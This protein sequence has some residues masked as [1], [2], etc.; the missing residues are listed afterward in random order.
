MPP[1]QFMKDL[2]YTHADKNPK[3]KTYGMMQY[4]VLFQTIM[5]IVFIVLAKLKTRM[6]Y[7]QNPSLNSKTPPFPSQVPFECP[8]N[9]N[10]MRPNTIIAG[11]ELH[12]A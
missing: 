11:I 12:P 9:I 3:T 7:E 4:I 8:N 6:N 1:A 5:I 10:F 2:W